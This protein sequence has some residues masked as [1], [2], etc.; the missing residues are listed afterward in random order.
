[1]NITFLEHFFLK[2]KLLSNLNKY[3][4][5]YIFSSHSY[6][7]VYSFNNH[8]VFYK[9]L[10]YIKNKKHYDFNLN[11]FFLKYKK[12]IY[13]RNTFFNIKKKLNT[14]FF[15]FNMNTFYNNFNYSYIHKYINV[16]L[17][18]HFFNVFKR[19]NSFST[20]NISNFFIYNNIFPK[21]FLYNYKYFKYFYN[22]R[23]KQMF[24]IP[25]NKKKKL[26]EIHFRGKKTG[27]FIW[28]K[29]Y[30]KL[31]LRHLKIKDS[32]KEYNIRNHLN[33][34]NLFYFIKFFKR[35]IFNHILS[36]LYNSIITIKKKR[37]LLKQKIIRFFNFK[38]IFTIIYNNTSKNIFLT[39]L[40]YK[41]NVLFNISSGHMKTIIGRKKTYYYT[42]FNITKIF[43]NRIES[44]LHPGKNGLKIIIK[45]S[46]LYVDN[47][48]NCISYYYLR[49]D[50]YTL[51]FFRF[52][53]F[54]KKYISYIK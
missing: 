48:L 50:N 14:F 10:F 42:V 29:K 7:R 43:L 15:S 19:F 27:R 36:N 24:F 5:F 33:H 47:F 17:N 26:N 41:G 9:S 39:F 30:I 44:F 52:K 32:L 13:I 2:G 4:F 37:L 11:R 6:N 1:M 8:N 40:N 46:L 51:S 45:G 18:R 35:S 54:M 53:V 3:Y 25:P 49:K 31:S 28:F 23:Y 38:K 20:I 12:N 16:F 22:Y 21:T 34:I